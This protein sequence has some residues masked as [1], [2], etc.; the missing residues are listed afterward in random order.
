MRAYT[1]LVITLKLYF[2]FYLD[3]HHRHQHYK[4][5]IFRVTNF[6]RDIAVSSWNALSH[7]LFIQYHAIATITLPTPQT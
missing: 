7:E 4:L 1:M 5:A 3:S 6:S 2:L